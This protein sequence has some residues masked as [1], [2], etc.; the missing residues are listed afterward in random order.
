LTFG[1]T[2]RH[3]PRGHGRKKGGEEIGEEKTVCG[4][5]R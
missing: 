1:E 5:D 3:N 2:T 4:G